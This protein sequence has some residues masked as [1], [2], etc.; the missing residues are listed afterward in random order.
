[1][2]VGWTNAWSAQITHRLCERISTPAGIAN[3]AK[4]QADNND[5]DANDHHLMNYA[6]VP[7]ALTNH[8]PSL[9]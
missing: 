5:E 6:L 9:V 7:A 8:G 1:M 3:D 4:V 2:I